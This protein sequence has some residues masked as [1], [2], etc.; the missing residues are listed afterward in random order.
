MPFFA[1]PSFGS[2]FGVPAAAGGGTISMAPP[3]TADITLASLAANAARQSSYIKND[4]N[5]PYAKI[6]LQVQTGTAP[7]AGTT[8]ELWLLR[9]PFVDLFGLTGDDTTGP[10]DAPY[11][12]AFGRPFNA[13]LIGVM[14]M[15]AAANQIHIG[16]YDVGLTVGPLGPTFGFAVWNRTNQALN[17]SAANH[18][19]TYQLY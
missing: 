13:K 4:A 11:P 12:A 8:V 19:L 14:N 1:G 3:A 10:S 15:I 6:T 9:S 17:A 7:T 2:G 16:T 5:R 18:K